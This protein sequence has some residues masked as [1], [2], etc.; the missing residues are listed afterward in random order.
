M[1]IMGAMLPDLLLMTS[2]K[3]VKSLIGKTCSLGVAPF[4]TFLLTFLTQLATAIITRAIL[5]TA[6]KIIN[7]YVDQLKTNRKLKR[8]GLNFLYRFMPT[9][10]D[11]VDRSMR[12][13]G[14]ALKSRTA[15][16]GAEI[17]MLE[18]AAKDLNANAVLFVAAIFQP[19]LIIFIVMYSS[20]L[21]ITTDFGGVDLQFYIYFGI[22]MLMF[23]FL[24]DI[25]VSNCM[26]TA[27][28]WKLNA[29]M[30]QAR[31]SFSGRKTAW[32][33]ND[34]DPPGKYIKAKESVHRVYGGS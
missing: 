19:I 2:F 3:M 7:R 26:E 20:E 31:K 21:G 28:G 30:Y 24:Y 13:G 32:I 4:T 25:L 27:Y 18:L 29:Y 6:M 12:T 11:E 10:A 14:A 15:Y 34:D 16:K 23:Q 22:I 17:L 5:P 8:C 9:K 33:L 1:A